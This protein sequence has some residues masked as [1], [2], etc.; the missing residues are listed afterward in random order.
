MTQAPAIRSQVRYRGPG[1]AAPAGLHHGDRSHVTGKEIRRIGK[2]IDDND[3]F[4]SLRCADSFYWAGDLSQHYYLL[5]LHQSTALLPCQAGGCDLSRAKSYRV[6]QMR[7]TST[8]VPRSRSGL[9]VLQQ[10]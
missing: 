3:A 6:M 9:V 7:F 8:R 4:C 2:L 1:Y 10:D 5:E